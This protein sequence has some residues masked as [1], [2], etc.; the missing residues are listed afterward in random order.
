VETAATDSAEVRTLAG[1]GLGFVNSIGSRNRAPLSVNGSSKS[2]RSRQPWVLILRAEGNPPNRVRS[3]KDPEASLERGIRT[4]FDSG[5][6]IPTS[7][8]ILASP[9]EVRELSRANEIL[10][11]FA[12][13]SDEI[14]AL[15]GE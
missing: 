1:D 6:P 13:F 7:P 3:R 8:A 2:K 12:A 15:I 5:R 14:R 4:V 10:K 9:N 11:S